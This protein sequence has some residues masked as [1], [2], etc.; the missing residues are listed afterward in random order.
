MAKPKREFRHFRVTF[1]ATGYAEFV[2]PGLE[3]LLFAAVDAELGW[4]P[5]HAREV[6]ATQGGRIELST[7]VVT[8]ESIK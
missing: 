7:L 3:P 8:W 6:L 2:P 5:E 4:S 1:K